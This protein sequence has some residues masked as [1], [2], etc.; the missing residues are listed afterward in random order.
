MCL[1]ARRIL[2]YTAGLDYEGFC[3]QQI[4]ID[5]VLRNFEILGEAASHVSSDIRKLAP[6]IDWQRIKDF[7]NVV[8]HFYSGVD[9]PLTWAL[10]QQRIPPLLQRLDALR[11]QV[12]D[13]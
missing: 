8:A 12:P 1:V 6:D 3:S 2:E 7:R 4:V 5:A 11:K 10:V 9:L 13:D